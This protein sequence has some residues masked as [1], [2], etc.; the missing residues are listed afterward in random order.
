M[1]KSNT[2]DINPNVIFTYIPNLIGF[3]RVATALLSFFLMKDHPRYTTIIYGISCLLDAFDGMAARKYNQSTRF[4]AVLDMVTDRCSTTSLICFLSVIYPTY[5]ILW[6]LLV[7]LDLSSHYMHMYAALS[8]GSTSHKNIDQSQNVL[9]RLYYTK[10]SVLFTVCM[11]NELFYMALYLSY[12]D[13]MLVPGLAITFP[14]LL[15]YVSL[16]VW[17]FK[18]VTN[19]IQLAGAA[20]TLAEIDIKEKSQS[21]KE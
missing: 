12:Y 3:T 7:S 16:P 8:T 17:F 1:T 6:Q 13:F 19:V 15:A 2:A 5:Y 9:L 10:K 11:F 4:G 18:Q 21:K 20:Y 14:Q